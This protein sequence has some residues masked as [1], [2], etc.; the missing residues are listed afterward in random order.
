MKAPSMIR[1]VFLLRKRVNPGVKAGKNHACGEHAAP[2]IG[3][4]R[5]GKSS[6]LPDFIDKAD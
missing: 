2:A 4:K 3:G 1:D 6:F 5:N